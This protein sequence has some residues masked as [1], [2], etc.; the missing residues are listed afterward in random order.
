MLV[1]SGVEL[2]EAIAR[3]VESKLL[4]LILADGKYS[5][6]QIINSRLNQNI[7]DQ[8]KIMKKSRLVC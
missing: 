3:G 8:I 1:F 2:D 7:P 5:R 4:K 6:S